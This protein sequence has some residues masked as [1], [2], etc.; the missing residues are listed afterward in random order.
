MTE[1]YAKKGT[2]VEIHSIVLPAG[3]RASQVPHDTQNLPLEMRAKGFLLH[4][5]QVG[6]HVEIETCAGRRVSGTL[7]IVNPA[8]THTFGPPVAE[9]NT[10]GGEVRGILRERGL[11]K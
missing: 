9:L 8:Y 11:F 4:A 7:V 1:L 2:W 6:D 5:A 10:I 3:E